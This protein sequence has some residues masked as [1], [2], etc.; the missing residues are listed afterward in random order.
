VL[1]PIGE[2]NVGEYAREQLE[3][4]RR[5]PRLGR[6]NEAMVAD[7]WAAVEEVERTRMMGIL[8]LH[9]LRRA[10]ER[11]A[12]DFDATGGD[13]R[14]EH[15]VQ[16]YWQRAELARAE[17]EN[18]HPALNAHALIGLNSA[19]DALVE[20]FTPAIQDLSF[21]V[22]VDAGLKRA[23]E[24]IPGAAERLAPEEREELFKNI[25]DEIDL[26]K[27]KRLSGSGITRYEERL[28]QVGLRAP[29]DRPIPADLDQALTEV[30]A[31]R[32]V[33]IHRAARVDER[34]KTQAPT[35]P[36]EEG[37]LV[38]LSDENY[39]TYSAAIRCYGHEVVYRSFRKWP[40][41]SDQ[42][43]GPDLDNWRGSHLAGA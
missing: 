8:G 25:R 18:N 11:E 5:D 21:R 38:R 1:V 29:E 19:L 17:I 27:L 37:E 15:E 34:A 4:A 12:K 2:D 43:D 40:E 7:Y 10:Y 3:A 30:G 9:E 35:L 23:E 16:V 28:E 22:I 39:R 36:Y 31:I 26:P 42:E 33:L 14:R 20:Q 6:G 32:D 24:V 41:V 13:R